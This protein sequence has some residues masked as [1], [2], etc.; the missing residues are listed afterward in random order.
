MPF[1][2]EDKSHA[3]HRPYV[4]LNLFLRCDMVRDISLLMTSYFCARSSFGIATSGESY[5][6]EDSIRMKKNLVH[7]PNAN[8]KKR[9]QTEIKGSAFGFLE[10][11]HELNYNPHLTNCRE[12][13]IF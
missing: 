1:P 7:S 8:S 11:S 5:L 4:N 12:N 10:D 6:S 2:G 9:S 3:V 13:K